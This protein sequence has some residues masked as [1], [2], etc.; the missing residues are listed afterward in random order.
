M[1]KFDIFDMDELIKKLEEFGEYVRHNK[2][3]L[4]EDKNSVFFY[5]YRFNF[6]YKNR[7]V[8]YSFKYLS[9]FEDKPYGL[10]MQMEFPYE[11]KSIGGN[12]MYA[13]TI[14]EIKERLLSEEYQ[15]RDLIKQLDHYC[16]RVDND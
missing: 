15:T 11:Y 7:D 13:L 8:S 14:D 12:Q 10:H 3:T 5:P 4:D 6:I 2:A 16:K 9:F 1:R